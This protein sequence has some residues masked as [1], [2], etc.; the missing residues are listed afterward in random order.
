MKK[1]IQKDLFELLRTN[2]RSKLTEITKNNNYSLK[3]VHYEYDKIKQNIEKFVSILNFE[4][5]G[6]K[7][8]IIIFHDAKEGLTITAKQ[9]TGFIN[10]SIRLDKGL[11][12][13]YI[14]YL[15]TE[16]NQ[17]IQELKRNNIKFNHYPI[18]EIIKQ[19]SF[20]P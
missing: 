4:E 15:E 14:F 19:E 18:E 17:L 11:F 2:S 16:K 9:K 8:L 1:E 13:E 20:I 12:V 3:K 5:L 10:N 6:F 7:R